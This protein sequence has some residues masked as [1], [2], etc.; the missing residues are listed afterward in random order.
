[1]PLDVENSSDD[2]V[3]KTRYSLFLA[4]MLHDLQPHRAV[5]MVKE[6]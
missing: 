4:E 2:A 6:I 1:L 5:F 3:M